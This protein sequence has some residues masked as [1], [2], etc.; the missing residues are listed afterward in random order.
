MQ[1]RS[2]SCSEF[3]DKPPLSTSTPI[4]QEDRGKQQV[5]VVAMSPKPPRDQPAPAGKDRLHEKY[6]KTDDTH[7]VN[8]QYCAWPHGDSKRNRLNVLP[9]PTVPSESPERAASEPSDLRGRFGGQVDAELADWEAGAA[10]LARRM[11]VMLLTVGGVAAERD[12]AKRLEVCAL[13]CMDVTTR[14]LREYGAVF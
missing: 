5:T 12:P 14:I 1:L 8:N 9:Q 3:E 6:Q 7:K 13:G 10:A 4:K 2:S 11:D